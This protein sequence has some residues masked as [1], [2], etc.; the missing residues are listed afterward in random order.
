HALLTQMGILPRKL[1]TDPLIFTELL[2]AGLVHALSTDE[3]PR[4]KFQQA[5]H[6]LSEY[7]KFS[8][9]QRPYPIDSPVLEW[10]RFCVFSGSQDSSSLAWMAQETLSANSPPAFTH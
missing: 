3:G 2:G 7:L 1:P 8:Q 10:A 5:T 9:D 4:S 6:Y